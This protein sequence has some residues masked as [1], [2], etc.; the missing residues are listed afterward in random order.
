MNNTGFIIMLC[1][2]ALDYSRACLKTLLAQT[3]PVEILVID[4]ASTDGT[5]KYMA[6]QQALHPSIFRM[7]FSQVTSVARAWNE[8]LWCAWDRGHKEALVVNNDTELLPETYQMLRYYLQAYR[9]PLAGMITAVGV[10]ENPELPP[11]GQMIERPHP[12]YSCYMITQQAHKQVPFD[13]QYRGGYFEDADHHIRMQRAKL[14]AGSINLGFLHRASATLKLADP[15]EKARIDKHYAENKQRFYST[16]GC[17]PGTKAYERLFSLEAGNGAHLAGNKDK[18]DDQQ[19]SADDPEHG[20]GHAELGADPVEAVG[21]D[22]KQ[23]DVD[24]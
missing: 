22:S 18:Q 21:D 6:H 12:D 13:Q 14:W 19:N 8:G 9:T 16:Y 11:D 5:A 24:E 2:N 3:V 15:A 1:R 17:V 4:N 7:S 23:N 10:R 20:L